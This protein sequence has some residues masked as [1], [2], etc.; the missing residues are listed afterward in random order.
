VRRHARSHGF[1]L[2]EALVSLL[3]AAG[4]LGGFYTALSTGKLLE[5]RAELTGRQALVAHSIL[6]QVG[7]DFPL[8]DGATLSGQT[9]GLPWLLAITSQ[10]E[11]DLARP[12]VERGA[13][14][15]I[16]VQ[17]GAE[18]AGDT[19]LILRSVRY[20]GAPL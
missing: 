4:V 20:P 15:Y 2:I 16:K 1:S 8:R 11:A 9:D 3:I 14:L 13:L 18:Q 10:P 19:P 7:T 6:D 17:V 12:A 5:R